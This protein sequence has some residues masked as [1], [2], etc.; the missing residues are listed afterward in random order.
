MS[1]LLLGVATVDIT[2]PIGVTLMG[3]NPRIATA[4]GHALRAEAL[5]CADGAGGGWIMISADVCAF[6]HLLADKVRA[7][8]AAAVDL[9][10]A[11][12]IVTATHT[13][14]GPHVSDALWCERSELESA[15]F[16]RLH[17]LLVE[18]AERAWQARAPGELVVGR[19]AAPDLGSNRRAQK[20]DG[21]WYNVWTDPDGLNKGYFDPTVDLLGVRRPDGRLDALLVNYGC[22]PVGFGAGYL[23]ISGDYVSYMKDALERDAAVGTTIF[24]VSGHA[25][26]D[27]RRCVQADEDVVRAMGER[28]AAIIGA[29]LP[30]LQPLADQER[31]GASRLTWD[32]R[33]TWEID[34]R[35][36]I[37]FPHAAK[38]AQVNTAV[39][40]W[41]V[42]GLAFIGLPGE[43][44]SE[45]RAILGE[46]SPFARTMLV[47]LVNDFVGYLPTDEILRQ[48]AYEAHIAPLS[49]MEA[50]L[51]AKASEALGALK[52]AMER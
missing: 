6:N 26:V 51:T 13:H 39:S 2:P 30:E 7:D 33:T 1:G 40:A 48:G 43:T 16:R 22:H 27:P 36:I 18:V 17:G 24:T 10:A 9:P 28:L 29:A 47:S 15:Y 23:A 8:V 46:I 31:A 11:A 4:V 12:V 52:K 50:E 45:Y 5:A 21:T 41:G 44:V 14:S 32:F 3:Y 38:G 19:A 35:M 37:Y 20:E 49:P 25:N 34:G 42:G